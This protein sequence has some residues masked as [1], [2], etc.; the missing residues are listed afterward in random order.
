MVFMSHQVSTPKATRVFFLKPLVE[1]MEVF[2]GET[3]FADG[4]REDKLRQQD[5]NCH[6]LCFSDN[7]SPAALAKRGNVQMKDSSSA[8]KSGY[9]T[10][11]DQ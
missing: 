6:P 8:S 5:G 1:C 11:I 9:E 7:T 2:Q 3:Q 4:L 10:A